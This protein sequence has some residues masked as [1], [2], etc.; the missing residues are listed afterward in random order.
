MQTLGNGEPPGWKE[1]GYPHGENTHEITK[2]IEVIGYNSKN[3]LNETIS[4][5]DHRH[6]QLPQ[7]SGL[8]SPL[9]PKKKCNLQFLPVVRWPDPHN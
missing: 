2:V 6:L 7:E 5:P 1:L 3:K 4:L 9:F 8:E